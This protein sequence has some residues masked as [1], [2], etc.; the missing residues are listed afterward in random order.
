M[1]VGDLVRDLS[2]NRVGFV[3]KVDRQFYGAK[4]A[5]KFCPDMHPRGECINTQKPD[6][7]DETQRGVCDRVLVLWTD[8]NEVQ[9]NFSDELEVISEKDSACN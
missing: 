3:E 9:Y 2:A 1:K 6:I 8:E 5:F 7:I 4:T